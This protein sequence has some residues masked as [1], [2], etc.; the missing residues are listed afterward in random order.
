MIRSIFV[1]CTISLIAYSH[2]IKAQNPLPCSSNDHEIQQLRIYELDRSKPKDAFDAFH[3][4]FRDE[5]LRIM[6]RHGFKVLDIWVSDSPDKIEFI[7]LLS[8][9]NQKVLES[10][11]K[12]FLEDQE[13]ISIKEKTRETAGSVVQSVTGRTLTRMDYSPACSGSDDS[14]RKAE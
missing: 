11:W 7:Y 12:S 5:A 6:K 3:A 8:W 14:E 9:P 10:S 13:W 2:S 1:S 4:R